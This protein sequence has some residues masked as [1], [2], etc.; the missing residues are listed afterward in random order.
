MAASS[1]AQTLQILLVFMLS[2]SVCPIGLASPSSEYSALHT[3]MPWATVV[4]SSKNFE[5]QK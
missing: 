1:A 2:S 5:G 3:L 4:A